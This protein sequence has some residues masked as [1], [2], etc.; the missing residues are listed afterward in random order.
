MPIGFVLLPD[1]TCRPLESLDELAELWPPEDVRVWVDLESPSDEDLQRLGRIAALD[2]EAL[3][4]CLHGEQQ[5]RVDE[6][7]SHIF[8]VLYGLHGLKEQEELDPHKLAAFCGSRF[9]ITVVRQ[10]C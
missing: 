1:N 8:L 6:F 3:E 10:P 5:P 4:D 9:L 2:D 7:E